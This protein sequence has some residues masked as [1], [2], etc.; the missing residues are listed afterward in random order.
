[1]SLTLLTAT[2]PQAQVQAPG[3]FPAWTPE[4]VLITIGFGVIAIL[5]ALVGWLAKKQLDNILTT[6]QSFS[7]RQVD[8]REALPDRFADKAGTSDH[9]RELY[10][11][12]D[13]HQDILTR[14]GVLLGDHG[15]GE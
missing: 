15:D 14:H 7:D 5:I 4:A 3:A 9:I 1:M 13:R 12:T 2:I 10:T 11:R 6:I 8:C